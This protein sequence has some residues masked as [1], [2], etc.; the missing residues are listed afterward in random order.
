[1]KCRYSFPVFGLLRLAGNAPIVT[2]DRRVEFTL[3][4]DQVVTGISVT[5]DAGG[6]ENW[7][8]IRPSSR[9]GVK[10]DFN[11]NEP[12]YAEITLDLR[13]LEG[14]LALYGLERIDFE[15]AS[16]E[17]LP[18]SEEESAQLKILSFS[19]GLEAI[20]ARN[21]EPLPLD[22]VARAVLASS[23]AHHLEVPLCFYRKGFRDL[24]ERRF[25]EAFYHFYFM[26]ETLYAQGRSG[27]KEVKKV[28]K[29]SEKLCATIAQALQAEQ[30][31]A[32]TQELHFAFEQKYLGRSVYQVIDH[33]VELRGLLHHHAAR[34]QGIWHPERHSDYEI[35][36]RVIGRVAMELAFALSA[37]FV[38]AGDIAVSFPKRP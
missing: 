10:A 24:R 26:I 1:M 23:R 37:P 25:I 33:F 34:K 35:D 2:P 36:A 21:L 7:P 6:P 20:D 12:R 14:F 32:M 30:G 22:L 5:V 15:A 38:L 28:L 16:A 18:E 4:K 31:N 13:V 19:R 3:G 17:W 9:P 29:R 8:T 11:L 27:T